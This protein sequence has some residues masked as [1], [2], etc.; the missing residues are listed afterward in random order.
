MGTTLAPGHR[1][2]LDPP[3]P[4]RFAQDQAAQDKGMIPGTHAMSGKK[5]IPGKKT[6]DA[7]PASA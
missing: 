1:A 7:T 2:T 6:I 4:L 3:H 5:A